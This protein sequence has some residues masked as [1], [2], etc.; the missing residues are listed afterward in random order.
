MQTRIPVHSLTYSPIGNIDPSWSQVFSNLGAR[1]DRFSK[2]R[3]DGSRHETENNIAWEVSRVTDGARRS[4]KISK[5][6][7][8]TK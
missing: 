3:V 5:E 7:I 1:L 2:L 4:L 6:V 8:C